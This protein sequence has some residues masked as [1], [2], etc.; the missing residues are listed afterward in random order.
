MSK[1]K[2]LKFPKDFLWGTSTSAYQVEGGIKNDWSEWEKSESRIKYLESSEL[3]TKDFICG[4]ACDSYN[5]WEE[6]V[7]L[8]EKLNCKA[9]RFSIEWARVEPDNGKFNKSAIKHY[10]DLIKK[11]KK[12]GIEPFLTLNHYTLPIWISDIGGLENKKTIDYFLRYVEKIINEIGNEIKFWIT[13]NEPQMSIGY[14]YVSGNFPPHVKNL[15]RANRALK[16]LML[17]HEKTYKLIHKRLGKKVKVSIANNLI[18]YT[19]YNNNPINKLIVKLLNYTNGMRFVNVA[20]PFQDFIALQYYHHNR[21]KFSLGG[22]FI[23]AKVENENK[24]LTDM[25]WEIY[26]AGIYYL[27]KALKKYNKPI[28]ITENGLSDDKDIKRKKFILDHL[29]YVHKAISEGVDV[30][31]YFHWSLLDNF[32]WAHGWAPKFGLYS[33]D[34]KTFKRTARP[35]AKVYSEICKRNRIVIKN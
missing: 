7:D 32:E 34:R 35:S 30:R 17:A 20:N 33:V 28:Y 24:E 6:D 16:N 10:Q 26:P 8:V 1:Q 29:K 23:I 4:Q 12:K 18:Y 19:P 21:M 27:L 3:N 9:Y 13:F 2:E 11:L 14:G 22:K 25:G 15:F 5:H 31:G